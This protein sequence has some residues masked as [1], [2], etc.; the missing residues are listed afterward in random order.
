MFLFQQA[1]DPGDLVYTFDGSTGSDI[2][3]TP[4][5]TL[6]TEGTNQ[7]KSGTIPE[8]NQAVGVHSTMYEKSPFCKLEW[9]KGE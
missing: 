9:S 6:P 8:S 7:G 2:I 4:P 5:C 3:P 1:Q